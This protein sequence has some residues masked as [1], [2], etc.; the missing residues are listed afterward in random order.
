MCQEAGSLLSRGGQGPC[1]SELCQELP[2]LREELQVGLGSGE[3]CLAG[4]QGEEEGVGQEG[5]QGVEGE[6]GRVH[7]GAGHLRRLPGG[8]HGVCLLLSTPL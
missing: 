8:R 5:G 6:G 3:S 1:S 4:H 7:A 2:V